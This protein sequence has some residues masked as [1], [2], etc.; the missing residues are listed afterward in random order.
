MKAHLITARAISL[1]SCVALLVLLTGGSTSALASQAQD[2][3]SQRGAVLGPATGQASETASEISGIVFGADDE[4][5]AGAQVRLLGPNRLL[6]QETVTDEKGRFELT[7]VRP[8]TYE[9]RVT[10]P[11]FR[12]RD[13]I[14]TVGE[15]PLKLEISMIA[16]F[17]DETVTVSATRGILQE[18]T[19]VAASVHT[20]GVAELEE[21]AV[22]LLP[23]MLA[24]EP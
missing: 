21:R 20:L 7:D 14:I 10:A 5:M 16:A 4:P 1:F 23:R 11:P 24:E 3:P 22:D 12:D 19:K 15:E 6:L 13:Q 17:I 8:G 18:N 9:L 2:S